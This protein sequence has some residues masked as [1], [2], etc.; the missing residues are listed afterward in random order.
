MSIDQFYAS[1]LQ[2]VVMQVEAYKKYKKNKSLDNALEIYQLADLTSHAVA[3]LLSKEAKMPEFKKYFSYLLEDEKESIDSDS[4]ELTYEE[5]MLS[6]Q[7][8]EWAYAMQKKQEKNKLQ[9]EP[10]EE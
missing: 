3:R 8:T 5:R 2:E 9:S 7:L 4:D 1:T 10:K 6:A